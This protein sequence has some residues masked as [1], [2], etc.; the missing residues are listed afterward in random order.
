MKWSKDTVVEV[1]MEY[2]GSVKRYVEMKTLLCVNSMEK[3]EIW[4]FF[5]FFQARGLIEGAISWEG[6]TNVHVNVRPLKSFWLVQVT[7]CMQ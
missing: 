2:K 7:I 1:S 3:A 6:T 5:F 4:D